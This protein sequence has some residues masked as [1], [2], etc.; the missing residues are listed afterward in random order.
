MFD[1]GN[2]R[3]YNNENN[4]AGSRGYLLK[5]KDFIGVDQE[6]QSHPNRFYY[7]RK[8]FDVEEIIDT[9]SKKLE[10]D[11]NNAKALF[12]RGSSLFKKI[13]YNEAINDLN[14]VLSFDPSHIECLYTRGMSYSRIGEQDKAIIDFTSVLDIASDHVNA[15]FARAAC[16]NAI[17]QFSR[18]IED[19]NF[20]LS[21]DKPSKD[22]KNEKRKLNS[23][24]IDTGENSPNGSVYG[25]NSNNSPIFSPTL[26]KSVSWSLKQDNESPTS[27]ISRDTYF[28]S[29]ITASMNS[30][31]TSSFPFPSDAT[32]DIKRDSPVSERKEMTKTDHSESLKG[33][34]KLAEVCHN[35]GYDMRKLGDF[36]G[37]V[38]NYSKGTEVNTI[39]TIILILLYLAL[40]A[41]PKYFKA[42]FNRGFAYDKLGAYDK[43]ISD[44][45]AAIKI[46]PDNAYAYYNRGITLDRKGMLVMACDDFTKAIELQP[47]N[48]DF[49]H[50]RAFCLRK[51]GY[52]QDAV[53]DYSI[54]LTISPNHFKAL[55]N[56]AYCFEKLDQ[57][58]DA[59]SDY[60]NCLTLNPKNAH[61]ILC[62]RACVYE[63][64]GLLSE[65]LAD[66]TQALNIGA[67]PI[68]ALPDRAK[69]YAKLGR[70]R[71]AISDL[72]AALE[73]QKDDSSLYF[74]R[75]ACWKSLEQYEDAIA[76][77]TL[78]IS[79]T[80]TL[81][82]SSTGS[83]SSSIAALAT[84]YTNRGYCWRKLEKFKES[85]EEYTEAINILPDSIRAYNNRAYSYAKLEMYNEAIEDYSSVIA[86]DPTNSHAYHNRGISLDKIGETDKAI[87]DFTRVLE[88][89]SL[90]SNEQYIGNVQD[91]QAELME[92]VK[93]SQ[94]QIPKKMN[95]EN[96]E[97]NSGYNINNVEKWSKED[98]NK[99]NQDISNGN[100]E[101]S[102]FSNDNINNNIKSPISNVTN[103]TNITG[104][105]IYQYRYDD[106]ASLSPSQT[107]L[108]D[109]F[110]NGTSTRTNNNLALPVSQT[111]TSLGTNFDDRV[112]HR[113]SSNTRYSSN[114]SSAIN[115]S[116]NKFENRKRDEPISSTSYLLK[117]SQRAANRQ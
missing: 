57:L 45:T 8:N 49:H 7:Y 110:L 104:K 24:S 61:V 17:G 77:Y 89:D 73:V 66:Y 28:G 91:I 51:L 112:L 88:L 116:P 63:R 100:R 114:N 109:R 27:T 68:P 65:S 86:I 36:K 83:Q 84:Y 34:S 64:L 56:R 99:I 2:N 115:D 105:S 75:A 70:F 13:Q 74:S 62:S 80:K 107:I 31:M 47:G 33:T 106:I 37:A 46:E 42:L 11:P 10:T 14:E 117:L 25:T 108:G 72:T 5:R 85:I 44:Y 29:V 67:S 48:A 93:L 82:T 78:A 71:N 20:A 79:Y 1:D 12:L 59:L 54:S 97:T 52:M 95:E 23:Y 50:N 98:G 81:L 35:K 15:A 90:N 41:D 102:I 43:A 4:D 92:K 113:V 16:Y 19:Y 26:R 9:C 53:N 69:V 39:I 101:R 40:E 38:E 21:M 3:D 60:N 87:T 32:D 103:S 76:D 55:Y 58:D 94:K 18:A 96:S 6:A 22:N 30:P 111:Q